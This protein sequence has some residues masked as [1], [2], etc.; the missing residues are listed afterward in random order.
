LKETGFPNTLKTFGF[1]NDL[2]QGKVNGHKQ[3][4][5]PYRLKQRMEGNSYIANSRGK[6]G[7]GKKFSQQDLVLPICLE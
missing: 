6:K 5:K 3:G 1:L 7:K 4:I 2:K